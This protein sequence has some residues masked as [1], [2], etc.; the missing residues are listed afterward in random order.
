[1]YT[2]IFKISLAQLCTFC[3]ENIWM[4]AQCKKYTTKWKIKKSYNSSVINIIL[5]QYS[6]LFDPKTTY[7]ALAKISNNWNSF[8]GVRK[9]GAQNSSSS[10]EDIYLSHMS[11]T[12]YYYFL[13]LVFHNSTKHFCT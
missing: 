5:K 2:K 8:Y 10:N 4:K 1:M 9:G 7:F 11:Y 13:S 6:T 12:K 3:N